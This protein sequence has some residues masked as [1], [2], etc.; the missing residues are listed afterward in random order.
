M[1]NSVFGP[2]VSEHLAPSRAGSPLLIYRTWSTNTKYRTMLCS[3]RMGRSLKNII[4]AILFNACEKMLLLKF[5]LKAEN[6]KYFLFFDVCFVF[7]FHFFN[8]IW[9]PLNI[10]MQVI[11]CLALTFASFYIQVKQNLVCALMEMFPLLSGG[12]IIYFLF[13]FS[14]IIIV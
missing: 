12:G 11:Y 1:S 6:C 5:K 8:F 7:L 9:H 10:Y 3:I 14:K 13:C 4:M 2:T